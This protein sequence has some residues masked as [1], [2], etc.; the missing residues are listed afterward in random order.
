MGG[1][2]PGGYG[3]IISPPSERPLAEGDVLILDTG[4]VYDGYFCDFDRNFAFARADDEVRRAYDVAYR[5][6]EAG[7]KAA[8]PGATCADLFRA[9]Q[10]V[11]EV[12]GA[13]GNDVGR[14]G[15]GLGSQLT[16]WPSHTAWDETTLEPGMVLTLEP[17]MSFAPGRVMVHEE[18]IVIRESGPEL[19]TRRAP[20]ELPLIG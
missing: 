19:L 9:M 7:L 4:S 15:H 3:D 13:L 2:G 12:G 10:A 16:E 18:N 11:L 14:L 17:G 5:A 8:R 6:T 1:A 20:P